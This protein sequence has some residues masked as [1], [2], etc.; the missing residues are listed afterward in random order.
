MQVGYTT[1]QFADP[2]RVNWT[3]TGPRPIAWSAWYPCIDDNDTPRRS[4]KGFFDLGPVVPD[5]RVAPGP[6]PVIL[7]SH[8]TGGSAESLGWLGHDL[9]SRGTVVLGAQHH[10]NTGIEPYHPAG[11]LCWWERAADLLLL[12]DDHAETG[13]FADQLDLDRIS[14]VGFSLGAHSVLTLAGAVTRMDAFFDFA[15][16]H[17]DFAKGPPEFPDLAALIPELHEQSEPFRQSWARQ[18]EAHLDPRLDAVAAIASPP[19][20]RALT[21]ASLRGIDQPVTLLTGEADRQAPAALA[22]T[23]LQEQNP[24][25]RHSSM[26]KD[27]GHY[28]FLGVPRDKSLIG[29]HPFFTDS[30]TV[31]RAQLH[32]QTARTV[33]DALA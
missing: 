18:G 29:R 27:V 5:A 7:L 21:R 32:Q 16:A 28:S 19:P 12:L 8:G 31:D 1:G 25:F 9:A 17:P 15:E 23:W 14:A 24:D 30:P 6:W 10:G 3:G 20:V 26:G 4:V 33:W 22:T 13:V 11:F 2:T